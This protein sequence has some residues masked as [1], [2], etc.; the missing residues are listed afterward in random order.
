MGPEEHTAA[1]SKFESLAREEKPSVEGVAAGVR[2]AFFESAGSDSF[3]DSMNE[4]LP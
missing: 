1:K 3:G 4:I 2:L